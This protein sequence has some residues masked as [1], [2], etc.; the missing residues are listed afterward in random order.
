MTPEEIQAQSQLLYD[1]YDKGYISAKQLQEGLNDCNKGVRNFTQELNASLNQLGTATKKLGENLKDGQQGGAV[2]NEALNAGASAASKA[3]MQFG[4]L[5]V[6]VGA[7]VKIL[8]FFATAANEQADALYKAN[9][10]LA[11]VGA[12]GARGM[13]EVYENLKEFGYGVGELNNMTALIAQNAVALSNFNG[14]VA[15]G[16]KA[17]AG[18]A[19]GIQSSDLQRQ[20]MNMGLSVDNI[21]K[22]IGNYITQQSAFGTSQKRSAEEL[23]V[24]AADY[25]SNMSELTKLTGQSADEMAQQRDEALAIDSFNAALDGMT[26]KQKENQLARFNYLAKYDK[27]AAIGYANQVSGFVGLTKNSQQLFMTTGGVSNKFAKDSDASMEEFAVGIGG[28]VKGTMA[29]Q[30]S[31]ALVGNKDTF[32]AYSKI[33]KLGMQTDDE[34]KK[35]VAESKN[36][37]QAQKDGADEL[38]DTSVKTRQAQMSSRDSMENLIQK[39]VLPVTSA[40][41]ALAD[42]IDDIVHPISGG[43]KTQ[44]KR[45]Q[46]EARTSAAASGTA[47][48]NESLKAS[49]LQIKQGDVQ[50]EGAAVNPKL[51]AMAQKIQGGVKGFNYFSSFNDKY[52]QEKGDPSKHKDGLAL[53]FTLASP[54]S[55]EQGEQ[56]VSQLKGMG[57]S[58]VLDEYNGSSKNKKGG[59][60]HAEVKAFDGAIFSGP[61]SGYQPNLTMH[62]DEA[63]VPLD[64]FKL[65]PVNSAQ[66]NMPPIG[67]AG[68]QPES[69]G[70]TDFASANSDGTNLIV[71]ELRGLMAEIQRG[72]RTQRQMAS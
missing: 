38:L 45:K 37:T 28:A 69:N 40:M 61:T 50:A 62:G 33:K 25:L 57:A 26:D 43:R 13:T 4:P 19:K 18:I 31:Q 16:A 15:Q 22:G 34:I 67:T 63:I 41:E 52:H 58:Y 35:S 64:K 21:N 65:T 9:Q 53:D 14:T 5:G 71:T 60:I 12:S 70:S 29:M 42:L 1:Q 51:M 48:S 2:F 46:E 56:I 55:K 7:V 59:H 23:K 17:M 30:R 39:G 36:Q 11:K 66:E 20:F 49:G 72:T 54:P 10:D 24:G 6:A 3:A 27:E 8:T 44:E 32:L 68:I 47:Q